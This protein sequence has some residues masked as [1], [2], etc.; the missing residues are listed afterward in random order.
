[1]ATNFSASLKP[2][3]HLKPGV[4]CTL[5]RHFSGCIR[6]VIGYLDLLAENDEDRIVWITAKS[7]QK[8]CKNYDIKVNGKP[9][10]YSQSMVEKALSALREKNIISRQHAIELQERRTF[11]IDHAYVVAPHDALCMKKGSCCRFMG[12]GRVPGTKWG[13]AGKPSAG[14]VWFIGKK[15]T[16]KP[17]WIFDATEK[18]LSLNIQKEKP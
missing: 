6:Q 12:P 10:P 3:V 17:T 15:Q 18:K 8:H 5:K 13:I 11:V 7:I 9:T 1:M 14:D 4:S 2:L 16:L